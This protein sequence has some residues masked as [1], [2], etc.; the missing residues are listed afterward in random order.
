MPASSPTA[1]KNW[2]KKIAQNRGESWHRN[3]L[4]GRRDAFLNPS[5]IRVLRVKGDFHQDVLAK[6]LKI[7]ESTFGAIE[8]GKRMVSGETAKA[9]AAI[10][11]VN[12]QKIFKF[13]KHN[14]YIAVVAKANI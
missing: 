4:A 5:N 9:I 8:R 10:L 3:M 1:S 7:S 14:K 12:Y 2:H 13:V 6:K 11:G